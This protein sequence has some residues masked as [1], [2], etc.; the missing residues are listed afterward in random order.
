MQVPVRGPDGLV[1]EPLLDRPGVHPTGQPEAGGGVAQVVDAPALARLG[2]VQGAQDGRAVEPRPAT[3]GDQQRAAR[4]HTHLASLRDALAGLR[5]DR[6]SQ[7]ALAQ[8]TAD[9]IREG[10]SYMRAKGW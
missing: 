6:Q 7:G 5:L 2:P 10:R 3:G 8:L 1:T 9:E 4:E